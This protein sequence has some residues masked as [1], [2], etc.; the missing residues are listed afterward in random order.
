MWCTNLCTVY[1]LFALRD[2]L[3]GISKA[4]QLRS[5][6]PILST[7]GHSCGAACDDPLMP[8][9]FRIGYELFVLPRRSPGLLRRMSDSSSSGAKSRMAAFSPPAS[10]N[11]FELSPI[12]P[13]PLGE[14]RWIKTAAALIIGCVLRRE[15]IFVELVEYSPLKRRDFKWEDS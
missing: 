13:N 2:C 11:R 14:G 12:P 6:E 15:S 1:R 4:P 9:F 10:D 5:S 3:V 7:R 8:S